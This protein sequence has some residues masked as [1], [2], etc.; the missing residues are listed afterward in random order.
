MI[1]IQFVGGGNCAVVVGDLVVS[2]H[3]LLDILLSFR[4]GSFLVD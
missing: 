4:K 1:L 3:L 2:P